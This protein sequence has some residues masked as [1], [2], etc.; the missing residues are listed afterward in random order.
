MEWTIEY[1]EEDSIVYAKILS[2]ADLEGIKQLCIEMDLLAREHNTHRYII[3]HRGIDVTISV[4]D[5]DKVP[6]MLREIEAD[7]A[8]KIVLLMDISAP[9]RNLFNFLKNILNLESM[10]LELFSDKDK[11]I[12]W[13]TS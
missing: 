1:L 9:K 2:P 13:L 7:F 4:F 6:D 8:G 12:A 3:D 5:L 11:A 10:D